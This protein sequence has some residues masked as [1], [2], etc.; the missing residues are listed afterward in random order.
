MNL[1]EKIIENKIR[2]YG[3]VLL[4]IIIIL[5]VFLLSLI[6]TLFKKWFELPFDIPGALS[7][8]LLFTGLILLIMIFLE[9]WEKILFL[10]RSIRVIFKNKIIFIPR[11][12]KWIFQGSLKISGD[13]LEITSSNSGCLIRDYLY[14]N[15]IMS[16]NLKI[17]NGGRAGI[18]FRAQDL[19]NY[20]MLQV[21]LAD[22]SKINPVSKEKISEGTVV[23]D[24]IPHIRLLGNLETFKIDYREPYNPIFLKY[25]SEKGLLINLE[26]KDCM[27]IITMMSGNEKKEFRW[28]IPTHAGPNVIQSP[29]EKLKIIEGSEPKI[30]MLSKETSASEIWFRNEYGKIGFRAHGLEKAVISGLKIEKI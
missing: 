21:E 25:D 14:K 17:P 29:E 18:I 26:I 30:N 5:P 13:S 15:F 23:Y 22:V 28:N 1:I 9:M 6:R 11:I 10:Y 19:E 20:L 4:A 3:I 24:I 27:A 16:F 8:T 7:T 12:S 2:R